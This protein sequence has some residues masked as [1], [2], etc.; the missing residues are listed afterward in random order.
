[1]EDLVNPYDS[2]IKNRRYTI[3]NDGDHCSIDGIWFVE[4][5]SQSWRFNLKDKIN[6]LDTIIN[7][8][9]N[10]LDDDP[11]Q[12]NRENLIKMLKEKKCMLA[13]LLTQFNNIEKDYI[14]F[15]KYHREELFQFY[16]D[17]YQYAWIFDFTE[18][19]MYLS[20]MKNIEII[21][22]DKFNEFC[23]TY[24]KIRETFFK[25]NTYIIKLKKL[26]NVQI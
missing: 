17:K 16:R 6:K 23:K 1:M 15:D 26:Y 7:N 20:I 9:L 10:K 18:K 24:L 2:D 13:D 21:I 8:F 5:E 22:R 12:E 11:E 3:F 4:T 14:E 19:S 25:I